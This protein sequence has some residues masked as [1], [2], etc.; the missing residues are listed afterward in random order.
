M[1]QTYSSQVHWMRLQCSYIQTINTVIVWN[2][3]NPPCPIKMQI[4]VKSVQSYIG[5]QYMI[6]YERN[7][8]T[9]DTTQN[10]RSED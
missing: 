5:L 7:T 9:Y 2:K 10:L 4:N 3:K 8:S 1:Q 6:G